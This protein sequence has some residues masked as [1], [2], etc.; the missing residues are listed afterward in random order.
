MGNKVVYRNAGEGDAEALT[1]LFQRTFCETFG[2]LYSTADLTAFMAE[3]TSA[4]WKEQLRDPAFAVQLAEDDAT[5]GFVKLGPVK[6]PVAVSR[7][8]LELRQLYVLGRAQG[9]GVAATLM[10]WAVEQARAR[11]AHDLY[12]AVY[13][14]NPRARRFYHR[15]GF[16]EMGPCVFMV[17]NQADSDIIMRRPLA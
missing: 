2:H 15:Y 11:G 12:L 7:P 6:L 16:T 8:A 1:E 9:S 13:T 14:D 4:Q 17:G 5:I 3:H 10:A